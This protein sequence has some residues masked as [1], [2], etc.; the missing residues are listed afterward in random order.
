MEKQT[1]VAIGNTPAET[2]TRD[3]ARRADPTDSV[4]LTEMG[5]VSVETKGTIRGLELGLTPKQ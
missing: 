1:A 5:K 3:T 2:M 4:G